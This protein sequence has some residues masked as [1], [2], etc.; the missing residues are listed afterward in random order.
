MI[1]SDHDHNS[2]NN[3]CDIANLITTKTE[4]KNSN[5]KPLMRL[6]CCYPWSVLVKGK[7]TY[8]QPT[9]K[10]QQLQNQTPKQ[11]YKSIQ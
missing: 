2:N 1:S 8:Q 6:N 9:K 7:S 10:R 5:K 11:V 3:A 4:T